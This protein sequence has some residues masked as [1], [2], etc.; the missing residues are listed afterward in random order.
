MNDAASDPIPALQSLIRI[1]SHETEAAA[2]A[3][4]AERLKQLPRQSGV[5]VTNQEI[6][7]AGPG[8]RVLTAQ[9]GSGSRSLLLNSHLDTVPP[10]SEWPA[11]PFV[12]RVLG[13]AIHGLGAADAK[14]SLAAMLAAFESVVRSRAPTD[15]RLI[16]CAVGMEETAGRGSEAAVQAGLH[17]D[18]VIVGE[19]TD[20]E[21]CVA[22]KGVLRLDIS[23]LGKA[24][25]ASEP[26]E[27]RNAISAASGVIASLD[28]L[29]A[30]VA[31]RS[32]EPVG[33]ASMAI[34]TINGGTARNVV[35]ARCILS[36]DRRLLPGE[37]AAAARAE[38]E[39]AV[40][41]GATGEVEIVQTLI[42]DAAATPAEAAIARIAAAA[43]SSARDVEPRTRGFAA[44]CDMR[45]FRNLG[46]MPCVILGP[47]SL[48]Q[49]HRA[50]E[51]VDVAEV[52]LAARI[53][54]DI[55]TRWFAA[56]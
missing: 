48:S 26:W 3:W 17:A 15:G 18:A 44:C 9:W 34:T 36:L 8:R 14:G 56:R 29:A 38:I 22:H 10:G 42:A 20:L 43:V 52:R 7:G 54:E 1:P 2:A 5:L 19:P 16:L 28:R 50:D 30:A 49:A 45:L 6:P 4:L 55:I 25:H 12:P 11:D 31:L 41:A 13:G 21:V 33:R 40:H 51:R 53:Y 35:P 27:G 23:I 32:E 46:G 39:A 24:A 47:G 37:S